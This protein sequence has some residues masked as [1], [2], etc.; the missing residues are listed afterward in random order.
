MKKVKAVFLV[1]TL[2]ISVAPIIS[3]V[4]CAGIPA[5][6][7]YLALDGPDHTE[8]DK[9]FNEQVFDGIN[10]YVKNNSDG[11]QKHAYIGKPRGAETRD[12]KQLYANI[13]KGSIIVAP[14]FVHQTPLQS[15][16]EEIRDKKIIYLDGAVENQP[17]IASVVFEVQQA[18]YL[19]GYALALYAATTEG[20]NNLRHANTA[21]DS[22]KVSLSAYAGTDIPPVTGFLTGFEFGIND[23]KNK[24]SNLDNND[25]KKSEYSHIDDVFFQKL[26]LRS[27]HYSGGY[28]SGQGTTITGVL[29]NAGVDVIMPVA[30]PQTQDT[31]NTFNGKVV[32]VDT[33]QEQLYV[34][35]KDRFLFS[36]LKKMDLTTEEMI[37]KIKGEASPEV[38]DKYNG[39]GETTQ[40]T[41]ENGL[42]GISDATPAIT[43]IYN[44]AKADEEL[45]ARAKAIN[46]SD[47]FN[48]DPNWF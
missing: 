41:I 30:G 27:A 9:S 24:I 10:N 47:F 43:A 15:S 18:A 32:G 40:G 45:I 39:L 25:P 4:S 12:F 21:G 42:V 11:D 36:V 22:Q 34:S 31:L 7:I 20:F 48:Y 35:N 19:G 44:E 28:A 46:I 37:K 6:G 26:S 38:A 1:S 17:N 23:A 13:P 5:T 8:R 2:T 14:G 3:S 29:K 33:P 16:K